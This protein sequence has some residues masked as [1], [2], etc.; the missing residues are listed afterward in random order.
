MSSYHS[1]NAPQWTQSRLVK[2]SPCSQHA[3]C[4]MFFLQDAYGDRH[5]CNVGQMD[6]F[7]SIGD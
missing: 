1:P 3:E 4:A 6:T 7:T 5:W 2:R